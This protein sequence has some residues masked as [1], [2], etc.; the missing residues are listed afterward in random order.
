MSA[1]PYLEGDEVDYNGDRPELQGKRGTVLK[2][3]PSG[4]LAVQFKGVRGPAFVHFNSL[5]PA[6]IRQMGIGHHKGT[7]KQRI[8]YRMGAG[9]ELHRQIYHGVREF[10]HA[11]IHTNVFSFSLGMSVMAGIHFIFS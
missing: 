11:F 1:G 3:D 8:L 9:S 6:R 7:L 5:Q 10:P 4:R 2:T